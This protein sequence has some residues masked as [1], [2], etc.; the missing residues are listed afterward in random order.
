MQNKQFNHLIQIIQLIA[1]D[2]EMQIQ[3]FPDFVHVPDEIAQLLADAVL[4]INT[5][6]E[7]NSFGAN[8][9]EQVKQLDNYFADLDK[10]QYTMEALCTSQAWMLARESAQTILNLLGLDKEKP[11]LSWNKFIKG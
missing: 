9:I 2:C 10:S 7:S 3:S 6:T 5:Q 8:F 1:S 4:L 11:D